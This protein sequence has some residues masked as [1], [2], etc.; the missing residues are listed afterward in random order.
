[1]LEVRSAVNGALEPLRAAKQLATT[2]EAEVTLR[3]PAA[4]ARRLAPFRDELPGF[5]L[6]AAADVVEAPGAAGL[7]IEA[8]RTDFLKCER[9]WTHR[10]DVRAEGSEPRLCGR[11]VSALAV[12]REH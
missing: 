1:M 10:A 6:V 2:L 5:L 3:A 8:R 9:C 7:E 12:R 11:C 4:L